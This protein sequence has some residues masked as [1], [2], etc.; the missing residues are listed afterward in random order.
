MLPIFII[1]DKHMRANPKIGLAITAGNGRLTQVMS[2]PF[3]IVNRIREIEDEYFILYNKYEK[4][5]EVHS[6]AQPIRQTYCFT[7]PFD[8]LDNR[9][10]EYCRETNIA[11]RGDAIERELDARNAKEEIADNR[12]EASLIQDMAEDMA[13]RAKHGLAQ[14]EIHEGY[15]DTHVVN[16]TA[17][18]STGGAEE[19]TEIVDAADEAVED[20]KAIEDVEVIA[21][22]EV[23]Y[24]DKKPKKKASKKKTKIAGTE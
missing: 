24:A 7:V 9:T 14:D 21:V 8:T 5:F 15:S 16:T 18:T 13:D 20:I 6:T 12:A 17:E 2:D 19:V 3:D 23:E 4:K 22:E 1:G 11:L 10:L